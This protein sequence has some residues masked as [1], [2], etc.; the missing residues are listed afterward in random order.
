MNIYRLSIYRMTPNGHG[1]EVFTKDFKKSVSAH[2]SGIVFAKAVLNRQIGL[3]R[4]DS[5]FVP[6]EPKSY[7]A[8]EFSV[9]VKIPEAGKDFVAYAYK[10]RIDAVDIATEALCTEDFKK[11]GVA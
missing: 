9:K 4:D 10:I 3:Y 6:E 11:L 2:L 5:R 1:Y 8:D 7:D